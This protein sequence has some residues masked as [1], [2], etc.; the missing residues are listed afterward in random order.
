MNYQPQ[1]AFGNPTTISDL[2][3]QK[4]QALL[5]WLGD[6]SPFYRELFAKAGI[7]PRR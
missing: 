4:L 6:R 1:T 2:Q 5:Q 3:F 7:D